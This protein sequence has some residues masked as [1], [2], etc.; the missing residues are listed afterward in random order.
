MCS[1]FKGRTKGEAGRLHILKDEGQY[2]I[3]IGG[4]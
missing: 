1:S 2:S 4:W 3:L